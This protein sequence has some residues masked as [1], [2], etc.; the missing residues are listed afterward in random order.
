MARSDIVFFDIET[1]EQ[2]IVDIGAVTPDQQTFHSAQKELFLTFVTGKKYAAGHNIFVHDLK[3]LHDTLERAGVNH[4][5]DTLWLSPLLFPSK[6]YHKL[7][8]DYKLDSEE[9]NNPVND[10]KLSMEVF[11]AEISAFYAL[12]NTLKRIYCTL[13]Q[14]VKEFKDFFLFLNYSDLCVDIGGEIRKYFAKEICANAPVEQIAIKYPVE[15]A[16]SLALITAQ[17]KTSV[18]PPWVL[19]TCPKVEKVLYFLR[20]RRCLQG[21]G[22][23]DAFLDETAKLNEYFGLPSFRKFGGENLQQ[24]AVRAA[25]NQKSLLAVFPTGGG[26]SITFQLP[27]LMAYRSCKGLTVV[28]SPLQSLMKDQVDNLANKRGIVASTTINGQLT[29]VEV[30]KE[31]KRVEEGDIA[32]LYISPESL[33]SKS[34]MTLLLRRSVVRFVI[35]EAHCFSVWGQTF[36]VDYQYIGEFIKNYQQLKNIPGN[37]AVS[38]FTATAKKRV[39][40]DINQ[41]FKDKLNLELELISARASRTNL[42]YHVI[43]SEEDDKF[44]KLTNLL[45]TNKDPVIVYVSRTRRAEEL[46]AKLYGHGYKA[47]P[48]H[49]KMDND[50]KIGNQEAF[51]TGEARIIV[52]TTAFGMGVDK[53]NVAMVI[54]YNISDSLENYVQEAGRAGRSESIYAHCYILFNDEDLNKHFILL[55]QTKVSQKE[56]QQIWKAIKTETKSYNEAATLS[57][58]DI[59]RLAGWSDAENDIETRVKTAVEELEHSGFVRREQNMPKIFASSILVKN[60][61]EASGKIDSCGLFDT[62]DAEH[63]KRIIKSLITARS[64]M[65]N[66]GSDAEAR[67]DYISDNLGIVR[68]DVVRVVVLLRQAGVLANTED[69]TAY[70]KNGN[71]SDPQKKLKMYRA[72]EELLIGVLSDKPRDINIKAFLEEAESACPGVNVNDIKALLNYLKIKKLIDYHYK[73]PDENYTRTDYIQIKTKFTKDELTQ[74]AEKRW[75]AAEK[76]IN[77]LY[78]RYRKPENGK[79]LPVEFS[80]LELIENHRNDLIAESVTVEEI[81]DA[82]FYILKIRAIKI[83]GEFLVIYNRMHIKRLADSSEKYNKAH[84]QHLANHYESRIEQIHIVGEYAHKLLESDKAAVEFVD[85]YFYMEQPFFMNKYFAGRLDEV[86]RNM[87]KAKYNKLFGELSEIQLKIVNDKKS[88]YIVVAAGPGSGKTKLLTH[89]LASLYISEDVKHEQMLMLTF[90]RAAATE[91]KKRLMGLI[92]NAANYI[93]IATFYS[94]CFDLMGRVGN[95]EKTENIFKTTIEA[96][97][98][99]EVD[100]NKI[101]KLVLVID[102]AQDMSAEEYELVKLLMEK[103]EEMRVIAVGDDD[104]NIYEFRGSSSQYLKS[105]TLLPEAVSYELLLNYRSRKNI[106]DLANL[107]IEGMPGRLKTH[108]ISAKSTENGIVRLCKHC[109]NNLSVPISVS[110]INNMTTNSLS[111][112]VCVLTRTNDEVLQ[113]GAL[114]R[115]SGLYV[116]YINDNNKISIGELA[117]I[118]YFCSLLNLEADASMIDEEDWD[119]A[120]QQLVL[121][122]A[123]SDLLQECITAL[124]DFDAVNNRNKYKNDFLLYLKESRLDDFMK[125]A[126]GEVLVST[127]HQAK[128]REFDN[129]FLALSNYYCPLKDEDRRAIYVAL[130]RARTNL[131][132]HYNGEVFDGF[133]V[134]GVQCEADETSY[135]DSLEIALQCSRK[136]VVLDSFFY[137]RREV[138]KLYAGAELT[139]DENGCLY[140]GKRVLKFSSAFKADLEKWKQKGYYPYSSKVFAIIHWTKKEDENT[141]P[142]DPNIGKETKLALP[143]VYLRK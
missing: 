116:K 121:Q 62:K 126:S 108:S 26:K 114:L 7:I 33:R 73:N 135:E 134:E 141:K 20:G 131:F 142:D 40:S 137:Y 99:N 115:K 46:A 96:L 118:R 101:G 37:I 82:L 28:I 88:K 75:R 71:V 113:I 65:K 111:G 69:F 90:S 79:E 29:S 107:F 49:G 61:G 34:M 32:I 104:Q 48:Y 97:K 93:M 124:S 129:V 94:F 112:T 23:C 36:R 130:T 86:R 22:Y 72:L 52:A 87:T 92:G 143:I 21:C 30:Q 51:M 8:K 55:N 25:L 119:K 11:D 57:A 3:Y 127:I 109:S 117:E 95:L 128:G 103:N 5:I 50:I 12:N 56:I 59:A 27:A 4:Y 136:S 60:M 120:T 66:N 47:L 140:D 45:D 16:Y 31:R 83:D 105:F 123:G 17:D 38:C 81:D 54:H 43:P 2:K 139:V 6:P 42:S 58:L 91:F 89:K 18:T 102:E 15:L 98:N 67:I 122:F 77:F 13:L 133:V 63:A 14:N 64:I 80:M 84:Y 39:I 110:V 78:D 53:N 1:S 68:G 76:I 41:Y 74:K 125:A 35:D 106:V 70:L 132:V 24:N 19:I 85:D 10:S 138:D 9:V 100:H 44:E